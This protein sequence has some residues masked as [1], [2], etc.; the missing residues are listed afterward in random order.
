MAFTIHAYNNY[1]LVLYERGDRFAHIET[2][3][4]GKDKKRIKKGT[5][6]NM[7]FVVGVWGLGRDPGGV[8]HRTAI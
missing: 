2:R 4:I 5:E 8:N 3:N 1:G 7:C 6:V